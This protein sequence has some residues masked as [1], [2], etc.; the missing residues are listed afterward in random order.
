[1]VG[2]SK[3]RSS[4][5]ANLRSS[6]MCC[7]VVRTTPAR[8]WDTCSLCV[9]SMGLVSVPKNGIGACS[10]RS[11]QRAC[12][13]LADFFH[14]SLSQTGSCLPAGGPDEGWLGLGACLGLV[15]SIASCAPAAVVCGGDMLRLILS[16]SH[17][18]RT[19]A[20][21]CSWGEALTCVQA[22]LAL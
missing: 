17:L 7:L 14:G 21:V 6:A 20:K 8:A 2:T 22:W 12:E 9:W 3:A 10:C 16:R 19:C 18:R 11:S 15:T 1:M 5:S 13:V 4:L